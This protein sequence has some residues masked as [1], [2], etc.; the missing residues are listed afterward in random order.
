MVRS[1]DPGGHAVRLSTL[2]KV[3]GLVLV[4]AG[5]G[6][7][8][9]NLVVVVPPTWMIRTSVLL[10]GVGFVTYFSHY[11]FRRPAVLQPPPMRP[12]S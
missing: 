6:C 11:F 2:L 12:D 4:V 7:G 5:V 10:T 3:L 8:V 1:G 9:Y